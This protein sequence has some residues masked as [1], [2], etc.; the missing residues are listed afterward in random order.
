[1]VIDMAK[2][3]ELENRFKEQVEADRAALLES[4]EKKYGPYIPSVKVTEQVDYVLVAM[5]PNIKGA[6]NTEAVERLVA[7]G[8][9]GFQPSDPSEPLALFKD[10]VEHYLCRD[11]ETYWLTDLSK[12]AIPPDMAAVN[13]TE[14]YE[15]WYPLLL[16][17]IALMGK[18]GCPVIAIGGLVWDFLKKHDIER[19]TCRPLYRVVHYSFQASGAFRAIADEDADGFE[20]FVKEELENSDLWPANLSVTRRRMLFA[21]RKWFEEIRD[22]R[23]G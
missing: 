21:Y 9:R 20:R 12:G 8:L 5:E 19:K 1:M 23:S 17:E 4:V 16:D 7:K 22:E 15:A 18:P 6:E 3:R 11:G 13:R 14:R 10:S 2:Y